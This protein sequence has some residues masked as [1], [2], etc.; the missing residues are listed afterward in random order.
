MADKAEIEKIITEKI[1]PRLKAHGGGVELVSVEEDGT[2]KVKLTG[3]CH[4]C[5]GAMMTLRM[6]VEQMLRQSG[7]DLKEVVAV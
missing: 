4:G 7:A 6:V 5:P 3:A 1:A 2:V